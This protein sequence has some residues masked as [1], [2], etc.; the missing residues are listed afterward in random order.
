LRPRG[1]T[2]DPAILSLRRQLRR[3]QLACLMLAQGV[4]LLLAGDEVGNSQ[5][6]NNNAYARTTRPAGRLVCLPREGEN[7]TGL[8]AR[9]SEESG[10]VSRRSVPAAGSKAAGPTALMGCCG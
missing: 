10:A 6:G 5:A 9:L 4:P 2:D 1:P 8:I 7:M 3:N